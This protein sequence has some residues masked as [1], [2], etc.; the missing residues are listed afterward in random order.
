MRKSET[1]SFAVKGITA[2]F[3]GKRALI[4]GVQDGYNVIFTS[5]SVDSKRISA[6]ALDYH[7]KVDL[8]SVSLT[9][10]RLS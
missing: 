4:K 9:C 7:C 6:F 2:P 3:C 1:L 5:I 8:F 10:L